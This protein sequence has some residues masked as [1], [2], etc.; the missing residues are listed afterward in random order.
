LLID[1]VSIC[2][3]TIFGPEGGQSAICNENDVGL[4]HFSCQ[5]VFEAAQLHGIEVYVSFLEIYNSQSKSV[6]LCNVGILV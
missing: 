5:Q 4:Y 3:D 1:T 2:A 6:T